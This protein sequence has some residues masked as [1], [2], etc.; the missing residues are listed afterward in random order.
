MNR[1]VWDLRYP[2][3]RAEHPDYTIAALP[4]DTPALPLGPL[5]VPG[6]YQVKL[7][8]GGRTYTQPLT[9]KMDPRVTTGAADL[10]KLFTLERQIA[11]AIDES[12]RAI[13]A[14]GRNGSDAEMQ[15]KRTA[16]VKLNDALSDLLNAVDTA[17]V[18]PTE[19]ATAAF[20]VFRKQLDALVR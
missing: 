4:G 15:Q 19:Q 5:V 2:S 10:T 11:A 20:V 12:A 17:D 1:F 3:P 8:A 13:A 6:T 16:L 18:A 7:L 9:V 14:T